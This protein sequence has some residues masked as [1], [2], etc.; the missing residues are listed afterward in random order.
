VLQVVDALRLVNSFD[1]NVDTWNTFA[2]DVECD[3]HPETA[4]MAAVVCDS[5]I[6]V[7]SCCTLHATIPLNPTGHGNACNLNNRGGSACPMTMR[8]D[9]DSIHVAFGSWGLSSHDNRCILSEYLNIGEGVGLG[10]NVPV[11]DATF[12]AVP[13]D[14]AVCDADTDAVVDGVGRY[15]ARNDIES[16]TCPVTLGDTDGDAVTE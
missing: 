6:S 5:C 2:V 9:N 11:V 15:D 8:L 14:V 16:V 4:E 12:D 1:D 10:T 3:M 13:E 7:P